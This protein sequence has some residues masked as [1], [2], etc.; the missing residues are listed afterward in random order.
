[1]RVKDLTLDLSAHELK[2]NGDTILT[3]TEFKLFQILAENADAWLP[4]T[5]SWTRCGSSNRTASTRAPSC[6]SGVLG[7]RSA[8]IAC[9]RYIVTVG[10]GYKM[11]A[12]DAKVLIVRTSEIRTILAIAV[13]HGRSSRRSRRGRPGNQYG[14]ESGR[15]PYCS[16]CLYLDS[17]ATPSAA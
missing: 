4:V 1:M 8:T 14:G 12:D 2:R 17:M 16:M 15:T 6:A 3:S 9:P 5:T 7:R 13:E 11:A 10:L